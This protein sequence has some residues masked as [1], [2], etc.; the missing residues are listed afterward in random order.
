MRFLLLPTTFL[1]VCCFLGCRKGPGLPDP[2]SAVYQEVVADFYSGI[3]GIQAGNNRIAE[4]KL[5]DVT[6][7]APDEP[8]A[9]VNLGVLALR[10]YRNEEAP[11]LFERAR[12]PQTTARFYCSRR[13]RKTALV[14]R[15]IPLLFF[16][17]LS[18]QIQP[19]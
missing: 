16:E 2:S 6:K 1:L 15:T 8:A 11:R 4:E 14:D 3:A 5:V 17:K 18:E 10:E 13:S 9:W 12:S 19:I 7:L